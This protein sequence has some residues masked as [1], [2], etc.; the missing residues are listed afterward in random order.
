MDTG[1]SLFT[2][3]KSVIKAVQDVLEN[4]DVEDCSD[5]SKFP[6]FKFTL[7][8]HEFSLPPSSYLVDLGEAPVNTVFF[9]QLAFPPLG[10]SKKD[11][12]ILKAA[13]TIPTSPKQLSKDDPRMAHQCALMIGAAD[14]SEPPTQF[15]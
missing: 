15:G 12:A 14:E 5:L 11:A 3:P 2:P 7:G 4:G 13:R 8:E 6:T 10:M 9:E 1:T